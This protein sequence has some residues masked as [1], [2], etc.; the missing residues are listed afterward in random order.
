LR[1]KITE[2]KLRCNQLA[3]ENEHLKEKLKLS[4]DRNYHDK[5]KTL[6]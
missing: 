5:Q 4:E 6:Q 2:E 1:Q 3:E